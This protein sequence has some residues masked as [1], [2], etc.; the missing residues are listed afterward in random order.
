MK[1]IGI[2]IH[3]PFCNGK[4]PYCN[5]Y[6]VGVNDILIKNYVNAVKQQIIYWGNKLKF[7][8]D[9]IYLGG[10]TPSKLGTD[11]IIDIISNIRK[12]FGNN[13][14]EIT[15][16]VNPCDYNILDFEKLKF[17]G[18][19]RIS[20]GAQSI[21]DNELSLLERKHKVKEIIKMIENTR[22]AKIDNISMDIMLAIPEQNIKSLKKSL[23][24]CIENNINHIS[25]YMLKIEKGTTYFKIKDSLN[26][27]SED[28]EIELYNTTSRYL[29]ANG[30]NHYEISNFC[31]SNMES[32]HN[33]KYWNYDDY[34]GIGPS[35]HSFVDKKRFYYNNSIND[36]INN[37]EINLE[38]NSYSK[39]EY[40]MLRLRLK[41]GLLND[42]F[43]EIFGLDIPKEYFNR[44]KK[45]IECGYIECNENKIKITEKGFLVSNSIILNIIY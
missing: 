12:Y 9:T 6:S 23:N 18:V 41:D 25:T 3:V 34:L 33:L 4:C 22:K 27:P 36:F 40:S 20:I 31:K 45:F 43:K 16:E 26:L 13:Q 1:N 44:A 8:A 30:Y 37:P 29:T 11:Y 24:F 17:Y 32:K 14:D 2:Y 38:N 10:G 28:Y 42:K 7:N 21:H 15:I 5:F 19:N 35:A 39:E